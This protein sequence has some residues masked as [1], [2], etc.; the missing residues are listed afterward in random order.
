LRSHPSV[1]DWLNGSD[2]P[3]VAQVEQRY[4]EILKELNWPNPYQSSATQRP[5]EV[6]GE[7][8]LKMTG[9][10][11]YVAPSYWLLDTKN[12]GAF[13]FITETGPGPSVPPV[14]SIRA[15]LPEDKLWP[16]NSA[17]DYHAGGG[18]FRDLH[19]FTEALNARY[20]KPD[21]LEEYARKAQVLAYESQRAMFEAFGRNKYISTG[22]IQWMA[23][24]AWP[25]MIWHLYDYYLDAGAGYFATKKACE[26]V[27]IQYSY[28]DQSIVV[29][30]STYAPVGGLHATV[31]VHNLAW[32]ELYSAQ[33]VVDAGLDS[34]QRVFSIPENLYSGGERLLFIDLTLSD[35]AKHV[36]SRNFYWVPTT[37]TTFDWGK[38]DYT[39]TPALRHEDLTVLT[40]LPPAK[41]Q[42]SAEIE[43]RPRNR[44]VIV[45]LENTSAVLAFQVRAA[46]RT[47]SG[48]LIAP[49]F[50][51]DNWVEIIPGESTMLTALLP[52]SAGD[53]P[54]VEIEGWNIAPVKL[55]PTAAAAAQRGDSKGD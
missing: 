14:E 3:P 41:V 20:G 51:S 27:H 40:N 29:V 44:K 55:M 31:H 46:V 52:E 48:G 19:V 47:T 34:A 8:G 22:V 28:D 39:H 23:N 13:G 9:P 30:N 26:P 10:Y 12:G 35:A 45:H 50:W 25:S 54:A 42:A 43:N 24:N 38:T 1:F 17:W 2:N 6:S 32:K 11:E 33:T 16:I 15:M 49:V 7:T 37:L 5:T 53:N 4:I 18:P 21:N 36:I